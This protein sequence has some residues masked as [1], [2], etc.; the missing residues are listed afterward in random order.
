LQAGDAKHRAYDLTDTIEIT[1]EA[2]TEDLVAEY[3]GEDGE[4][5][6]FDVIEAIDDFRRQQL[7]PFEVLEVIQSFRD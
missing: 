3:A 1:A 2:P 5:G 7:D 6:S 4:V